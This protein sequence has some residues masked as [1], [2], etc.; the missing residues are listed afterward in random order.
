VLFSNAPRIAQGQAWRRKFNLRGPSTMLFEMVDAGPVEARTEGPGVTVTLTPLLGNLAPRADGQVPSRWDVEPG[1]YVLRITPVENAVGILDLTFGT[2]GIETNEQAAPPPRASI[3]LGV[4][5]FAREANYQ[6]F[7][8][9]APQL[10]AGPVLRPLPADIA[11]TPLALHQRA[12]DGASTLEVRIPLDGVITATDVEGKP[13]EFST[14]NEVADKDRRTMTVTLPAA[15]RDRMVILSWSGNAKPLPELVA[16]TALPSLKA[17]QPHFFDLKN[18]E[19]RRFA[20]D[21]AEGGLYRIET[22]GRLKTGLEIATPYLPNLGNASDN[23]PGHNA[24]L[25]TYL[26]AG[27][28]RVNVSASDS[29]GRLA[30]VANPAPLPSAGVL[31]PGESG[32]AS[33]TEGRGVVF[34]IAVA[35]AGLYRLDLYG[36]GRMPVARLEDAEGWPITRPGPVSRLEQQLAAGRYRL[37]VLPQPTDTRVVARLRRVVPDK[38]PEGHG[39]HAIALDTVQKFQWREP[40]DRNA[41]RVPDRWEFTLAGPAN[42]VLETSDGMIGDLTKIGEAKPVAK[43]VHKRGFSGTL[44]AGRYAIEA[45]SL[46]RNDRLDYELTL[47]AT[48]IQPGRARLVDLPATIPFAIAADRVVS[49]TTYG[50][51]DLSAILKDKDG[52]VIERLSGRTDDWNI[53]MSRLLPAGAYQFQLTGR[54]ARAQQNQPAEGEAE[55]SEGERPEKSIEVQLALPDVMPEPELSFAKSVE[56]T[57]S[58]VHQF[59]LPRHDAGDLLLVAAQSSAELVVSLERQDSSGRWSAAGFRRGKEVFIAAPADADRRPWRAAVWAV[60]GGSARITVAARAVRVP[61]Q[62]LGQITLA[63]QTLDGITRPVAVALVAIPAS[64]LVTAQGA[65]GLA[66][67]SKPGRVLSDTEGGI[68][69]AQSERLWLAGREVAATLEVAAL[70]AIT[71]EV[72]LTLAENDSAIIPQAAV[73]AGRMRIWRAESTFGQPGLDA[74]RRMGVADGSALASGTERLRIWNADGNEA[75]RLRVATIDLETRS[76]APANGEFAALLPPRSAQPLSLRPGAKRIEINLVAGA[77]A[78]LDGGDRAVTVWGGNEAVTRTLEGNWTSV[79][80]LNTADKPAPVSLGLA[81]AQGE[82]TLAADKVMK[83]FYGAAGSLSLRLEARAGDR[84]VTAGATATFVADGGGV[85]R[86]TSLAPSGPGELIVDHE[87]GLVVAWIERGGT[88]PWAVSA[89]RP[90]VAPQSVKLDGQAMRFSLKQDEPVLLHARTT[91]PVILS[92][93]Q[94]SGNPE[95]LLYP[96]GAALHR[97]VGAGPSELRLYSPHDGPLAGSLEL[98]ATPV[99]RIGEGLGEARAVAPGATALF[100]FEVSRAGPVGVGIRSE[101]DR[102]TVRLLDASG[103]QLGEGVAQLHRLDPGRYL[104]EARIPANG[105]TTTI[106]PAVIGISPPPAGPPPEVTLQYLE[107]VGLTPPQSR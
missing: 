102:A 99:V 11:S 50:R 47:R 38:P 85:A 10:I 16:A 56:V 13:V 62:P 20:L 19:R 103:K 39:P 106:R 48:E 8:N 93:A 35:E 90:I 92:L 107:M 1:W 78:L 21:V 91:A 40:Q 95:V 73:P 74:G 41:P 9:A 29:A 68:L 71:G 63:P 18:N 54:K 43:I 80:L 45:R 94:G 87:A 44:D 69:A 76:A 57:G 75:L 84:L 37:V 98:T 86:G 22:L 5:D 24:L 60:D 61:A 101:P 79:V 97:Y 31:V 32:R 52:R 88:S 26:R 15:A 33:L 49:L 17:A 27:T 34:P 55:E 77:A 46:G 30:L 36:L 53:A 23:G 28:Y 58:Q 66:E 42:I 100:G 96:A 14:S 70:P 81:P 72:A 3:Q 4:H 89:A 25:Q 6:V 83:R 7:T 2:P 82:A 105:R 64:G 67:G 12:A 65:P 59:A 51:E 104:V